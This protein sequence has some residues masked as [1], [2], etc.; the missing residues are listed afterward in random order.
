MVTL[1]VRVIGFGGYGLRVADKINYPF[2]LVFLLVFL[3]KKTAKNPAQVS[4]DSDF[5]T[6]IILR[7]SHE[8]F[9]VELFHFDHILETFRA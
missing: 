7:G 6:F 1:F 9:K 2:L 4:L 3:I 5:G 8:I